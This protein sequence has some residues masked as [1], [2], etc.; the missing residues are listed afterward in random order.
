ML[1]LVSP[2]VEVP[3]PLFPPFPFQFLYFL[4]VQVFFL[5]LLEEASSPEDDFSGVL[6]PLPA[7]VENLARLKHGII[8][9][10]AIEVKNFRE[11]LLEFLPLLALK[12]PLV[13]VPRCRGKPPHEVEHPLLA[14]FFLKFQEALEGYHFFFPPILP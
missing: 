7:G 6:P 11:V 2:G 1:A 13:A 14:L 8:G 9:K 12:E 10:A 4:A 5:Q 3:L